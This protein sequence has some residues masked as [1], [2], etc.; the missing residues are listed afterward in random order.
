[1]LGHPDRDEWRLLKNQFDALEHDEGVREDS[2]ETIL[3]DE[4]RRRFGE[5]I[6]RVASKAENGT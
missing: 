1:M 3:D 5:W 2:I 4:I 6:A